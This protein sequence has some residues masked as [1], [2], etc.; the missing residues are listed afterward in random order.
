MKFLE[1]NSWCS[2]T[3]LV[4]IGALLVF[5]GQRFFRYVMGLTGAFFTFLAVMYISDLFGFLNE[6]WSLITISCV[7]GIL[8]I[9]LGIVIFKSIPICIGLLG[10]IAGFFGAV[11]IFSIIVAMTGY[12]PLWL[13]I[14]M[15]VTLGIAFGVVAF[16]F[17]KGFLSFGTAFVG[18][19]MFMRGTALYFGGYPGEM[20]MWA[21][22]AN[23]QKVDLAW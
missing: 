16:K 15:I 20:Q 19:Y 18:G 14:T 17:S 21:M 2:G 1:N 4:I 13:C 10:V 8:A 7:S 22:M 12:D 6:T 5:F 11:L 23:G 9:I 3:I